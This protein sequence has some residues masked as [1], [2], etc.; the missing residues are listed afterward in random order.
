M[1]NSHGWIAPLTTSPSL[2]GCLPGKGEGA[3]RDVARLFGVLRLS[4][5]GRERI[6]SAIKWGKR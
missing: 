1:E 6:E 4:A 2:S 5:A 3:Y